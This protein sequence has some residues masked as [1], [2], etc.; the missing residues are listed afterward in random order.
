MILPLSHLLQSS[1]NNR[2]SVLESRKALKIQGFP[3]FSVFSGYKMATSERIFV[4]S[5]EIGCCQGVATVTRCRLTAVQPL[6]VCWGTGGCKSPLWSVP[7]HDP[8]A[9]RSA[10]ER[11]PSLL[12]DWRG[13]DEYHARGSSLL[14]KPC[15]H[16]P[17]LD[18][19]SFCCRET[20][21][22]CLPSRS[23][24]TYTP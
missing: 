24:G 5:G 15:S 22:P 20:V 21:C 7:V 16:T 9:L 10:K 2:I 17:S 12:A 13:C 6:P 3:G 1:G 23:N 11:S 8:A 4:A 19:E 18:R 14:P